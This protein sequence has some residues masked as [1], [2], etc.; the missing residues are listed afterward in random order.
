VEEK[1]VFFRALDEQF[2]L[3]QKHSCGFFCFSI[4][5]AAV[6]ETE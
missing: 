1:D 6:I 2:L 3:Q 4:D 5:G